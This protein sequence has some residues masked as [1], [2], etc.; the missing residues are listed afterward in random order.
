[1]VNSGIL[2]LDIK[3]RV[4]EAL[5]RRH[6][7]QHEKRHDRNDSKNRLPLIRSLADIG[8][9][10]SKSMFSSHS[11]YTTKKYLN[12][13]SLYTNSL[14]IFVLSITNPFDS[15]QYFNILFIIVKNHFRN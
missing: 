13:E 12:A 9:N 3:N 4:K 15:A 7:H 5:L 8:R 1:M 14:K 2:S 11:K 10:S 6:R